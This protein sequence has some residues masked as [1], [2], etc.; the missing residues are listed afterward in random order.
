MSTQP[1]EITRLR[2]SWE[3][4]LQLPDHPRNEWVDGEV[5]VM[6]PASA[7]HGAVAIR[8]AAILVPA[9]PGL[10]ILSE[11]GVRLPRNRLRAPDLAAVAR[12]PET[13]WVTEPPVLVVEV[14]SPSTRSEDTIRKSMEYA[15]AGIGQY[16]IVDPDLRAIDVLV[17][18]DGA[19]DVL[20][21]LDE[22]HPTAEVDVASHGA[23]GLDLLA[24]L[25]P[26]NAE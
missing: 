1:Q 21:H 15:E 5:L 16:W 23:V 17:N 14:L 18:H 11:A 3:E 13:T 6:S 8:L 20:A 19:W 4:F 22:A 26:V 25:D 7:S 9:L 12:L 10:S 24:V 2:M